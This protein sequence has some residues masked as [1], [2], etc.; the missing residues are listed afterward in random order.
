MPRR[1]LAQLRPAAT[2]AVTLFSPTTNRPYNLDLIVATNNTAH[3]VNITMYHDAAGNTY[4]DTTCVLATTPLK[5]GETLQYVLSVGLA[6]YRAAG[7]LGVKTS[8]ADSVNFTVYGE[9]EGESI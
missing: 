2:S 8:T 1:L 9:L 3:S 7:G 6:D 4:D 5:P